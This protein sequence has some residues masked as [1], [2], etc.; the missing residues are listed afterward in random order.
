MN[1]RNM[2][3]DIARGVG[4]ILMIMNHSGLSTDI[5]I[6]NFV[7]SFYMPFFFL[8]SGYF[9]KKDVPWK[10]YLIN[11]AKRLLLPYG[12]WA[13][14]H[15]CVWL[16]MEKV[17]IELRMTKQQA[18]V[19]VLW[20]N[21]VYFPIA[22]ALWFLTSLFL[23]SVLCKFLIEKNLM[24]LSLI[25]LLIGLYINPFLPFSLDTALIG[26]FFF[27]IGYNDN[28]LF[29]EKGYMEKAWLLCIAVILCFALNVVISNIN[30]PVNMRECSYG[31][32]PLF[33]AITGVLGSMALLGVSALLNMCKE[34]MII[35]QIDKGL[36]Y[37]GKNSMCYLCLNQL[38]ITIIQHLFSI[39]S[40]C[41]NIF[42]C[43]IT[44]ILLSV[45]NY[46]VDLLHLKWVFGEF[47]QKKM[48]N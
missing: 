40:I 23:V 12:L 39:E 31:R 2:A 14:F 29:K 13:F 21:N 30:G 47:K 44:L 24:W 34:R 33:F 27:I 6:Y 1:K 16:L 43:V 42:I 37:I 5:G 28:L 38:I 10:E 22:G 48:I 19:G 7:N 15:L 20:N 9:F 45:G 26:Q 25:I 4:I 46:L 32:F 35:R 41:M 8:I 3:F 36:A 11:K 18:V 17:G